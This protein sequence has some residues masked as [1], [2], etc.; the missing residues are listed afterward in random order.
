MR[1]ERPDEGFA[2]LVLGRAHVM[3]DRIRPDSWVTAP[4]QPPLGR[5]FNLEIS[6]QDVQSAIYRLQAADWP[7]FVAPQEVW[8]RTGSTET[9]ARE[10]CA[11]DPG[12]YLVRLS[13]ELGER[14]VP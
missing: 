13:Q 1:Y 6:V 3:L 10:F 5:G 14:P 2:Y 7:F 12:G 9:G 11:Q 8:Y 4:L